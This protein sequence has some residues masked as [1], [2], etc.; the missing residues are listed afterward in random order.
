MAKRSDYERSYQRVGKDDDYVE[1][2]QVLTSE[3]PLRLLKDVKLNYTG[4]VT[5]RLYK[6]SG[7]GSIVYVDKR[8]ADIMISKGSNRSC[9]GSSATPYFE[10]V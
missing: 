7:A 3:I 2:P 4:K 5:G 8:D 9:C 1:E 10:L 6:F